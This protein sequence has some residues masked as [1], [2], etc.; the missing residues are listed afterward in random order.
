MPV[1]ADQFGLKLGWHGELQSEQ[2]FFSVFEQEFHF[3]FLIFLRKIAGGYF[4]CLAQ[5]IVFILQIGADII[6]YSIRIEEEKASKV[7]LPEVV[8]W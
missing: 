3:K 2:R 8:N 5:S 6:F 4:I 1:V 7:S